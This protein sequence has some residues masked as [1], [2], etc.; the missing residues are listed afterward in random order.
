MCPLAALSTE[1]HTAQH[2]I[3]T[4]WTR[5]QGPRRE[6]GNPFSTITLLSSLWSAQSR[7]KDREVWGSHTEWQIISL[8]LCRN[9]TPKILNWWGHWI[10]A[11]HKNLGNRWYTHIL[12]CRH[13]HTLGNKAEIVWHSED[14][15]FCSKFPEPYFENQLPK[16]PPPP[17]CLHLIL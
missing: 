6:K 5:W 7:N 9:I 14:I 17:S 3:N 13:T 2:W 16:M 12:T 8:R 15:R 4:G 11:F 10:F 1:P